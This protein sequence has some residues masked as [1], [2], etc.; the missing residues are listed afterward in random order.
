MRDGEQAS[1]PLIHQ[2][3][4]SGFDPPLA[5]RPLAAAEV[6][7]RLVATDFTDGLVRVQWRRKRVMSGVGGDVASDAQSVATHAKEN[8]RQAVGLLIKHMSGVNRNGITLSAVNRL[9]CAQGDCA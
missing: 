5:S 9:V 2:Q 8:C 7:H 6:V 3:K 1:E 4:I